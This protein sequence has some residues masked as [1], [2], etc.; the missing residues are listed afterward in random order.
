MDTVLSRRLYDH[1]GKAATALRAEQAVRSPHL[2]RLIARHFPE[3]REAVVLDVGCGNG[4]LLAEA[5]R[6]GYRNLSGVDSSAPRVEAARAGGLSTVACRD[7]LAHLAGLPPDSH[8]LI[9]AFDV[10]E[11]F[12]G[13]ELVTLVDSVRAALRPGG[14]WLIHMPNGASPFFGQVFHGDLTHRTAFT[15]D[16]LRWLLLASGFREVRCFEDVPVVHGAKS[17]VRRLG[18]ALLRSA[19]R[20]WT[21]VETGDTGRDAV[22]TRCLLAVAVK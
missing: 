3:D 13:D 11:H 19:L 17:L 21:M 7:L 22:L 8:D 12:G 5:A 10:L 18:W 6:R 15:A 14:R 4:Q 2:G 1:D 9:V 16:S 20:L